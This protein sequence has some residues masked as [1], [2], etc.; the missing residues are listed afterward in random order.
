MSMDIRSYVSVQM[1]IQI[2]LNA[3][4]LE[5]LICLIKYVYTSMKYV[6]GS[7]INL[8]ICIIQKGRNYSYRCRKVL[9]L[10]SMSKN[11]MEIT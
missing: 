3:H 1:F 8:L 4:D 2:K 9:M 7:Y 11:Y 5:K 6:H 10:Y